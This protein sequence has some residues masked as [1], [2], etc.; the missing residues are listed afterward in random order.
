MAGDADV[1]TVVPMNHTWTL[2]KLRG[3]P[4]GI[5]WS[6]LVVLGLVTGSIGGSLAS[7]STAPAVLRYLVGAVAAVLFVGGILAHELGHVAAAQHIGAPVRRVTLWALGG[8]AEIEGP[9]RSPGAAFAVAVAGP[10]VSALV[11]AGCFAA[12]FAAAAWGAPAAVVSAAVWLSVVNV[13]VAVFNMLPIS[14][15]DGGRAVTAVLWKLSGSRPRAEAWTASV[16]VAAGIAAIALGVWGVLGGATSPWWVL[17]GFFVTQTAG[18]ELAFARIELATSGR[19]L[20]DVMAPLGPAVPRGLTLHGVHAMGLSGQ[21]VPVAGTSAVL[22]P[23]VAQYLGRMERERL[24][25]EVLASPLAGEPLDPATSLWE[26]LGAEGVPNRA[27]PVHVVS[28]GSG[29]VAG[30]V[31]PEVIVSFMH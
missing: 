7:V 29:R 3:V 16:G 30:V 13:V 26:F 6:A 11:A 31:D 10:A 21:W 24:P 5:H 20:A 27:G 23:H 9:M 18:R 19:T 17:L 15:L 12:A 8:V 22:S 28:D 14:P 25:V 1:C 4:I 2:G